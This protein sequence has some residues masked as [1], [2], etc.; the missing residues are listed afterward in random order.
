[1]KTIR[2]HFSQRLLPN[3]GIAVASLSCLT[4]HT[5][6]AQLFEERRGM[7]TASE[8]MCHRGLREL[9]ELSILQ[10]IF[11]VFSLLDLPDE[12]SKM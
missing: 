4:S 8:R 6:E 12:L 7:W 11:I 9:K 3:F 2:L 10:S 1:M 5:L